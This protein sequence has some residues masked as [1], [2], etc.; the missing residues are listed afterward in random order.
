MSDSHAKFLSDQ[1]PSANRVRFFPYSIFSA[2]SMVLYYGLLTDL[3][4]FSNKVSA[5]VLVV[6]KMIP[7]VGLFLMALLGALLTFSSAFSCLDQGERDFQ[8][9]QSGFMPLW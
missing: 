4:V 1:C 6:G 5:Y 9:I 7:E 8:G 2:A 3:A